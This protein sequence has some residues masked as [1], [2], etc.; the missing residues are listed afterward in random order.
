MG[1]NVVDMVLDPTTSPSPKE[2][3]TTPLLSSEQKFSNEALPSKTS[4]R[5]VARTLVAIKELHRAS[6]CSPPTL[7]MGCIRTGVGGQT[8]LGEAGASSADEKDRDVS[9]LLWPSNAFISGIGRPDTV[10]VEVDPCDDESRRRGF[11]GK[12]PD[13]LLESPSSRTGRCTTQGT[14]GRMGRP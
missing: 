7:K 9:L 5:H 4:G 12:P 14:R 11:P 1:F 13:L 3:C 8:S 2:L 6:F 10:P